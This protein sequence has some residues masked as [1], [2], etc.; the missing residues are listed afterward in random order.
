MAALA[1]LRVAAVTLLAALAL[2]APRGSAQAAPPLVA[3][4]ASTSWTRGGD[5][6]AFRAAS[7]SARRLTTDTLWLFGDSLRAR[8]RGG[9]A[10][11]DEV[12]DARSRVGALADRAAAA[13][14]PL[15]LVTDGEIDES[16]ALARAPLGSRA[17]VVAPARGPDAGVVGLTLPPSGSERDTV[18]AEVL[19]GGQ[20]RDPRV[21][22]RDKSGFPIE[23]REKGA[24]TAL[25]A[26]LLAQIDTRAVGAPRL[27]SAN[28]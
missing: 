23:R 10:S 11:V 9:V 6:A 26:R 13:G 27:A 4:D 28:D 5:S 2:D 8:A 1:L 22:L 16:E 24:F 3:L 14:R 15:L 17:I 20:Q 7:D 25:R 12:R 19:V 21:A 18:V